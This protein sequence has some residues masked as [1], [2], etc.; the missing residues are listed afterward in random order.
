MAS[1]SERA[2][3]VVHDRGKSYGHPAPIYE[4][5]AAI[6]SEILD[7]SVSPQQV[8]LCMIALKLGREC[9][10]PLEDNITDICG[11]ANVYEMIREGE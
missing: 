3:Q 6:W 7:T 1:P 8:A 9:V 10:K 4:K 11:Y 2:T 5:V